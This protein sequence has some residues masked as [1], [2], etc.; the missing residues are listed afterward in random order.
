M[1]N[2]FRSEENGFR[3]GA[4][5]HLGGIKEMK[6]RRTRDDEVKQQR[7]QNCVKMQEMRDEICGEGRGVGKLNPSR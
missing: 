3:S 6:R 1:C 5:D 2:D 4:H 7:K